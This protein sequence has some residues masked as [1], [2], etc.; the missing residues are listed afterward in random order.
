MTYMMSPVT[1][2]QMSQLLNTHQCEN[3]S[4]VY[5]KAGIRHEHQH[6]V[7]DSYNCLVY[8]LNK[9]FASLPEFLPTD[10]IFFHRPSN[11]VPFQV[12]PDG[13]NWQAELE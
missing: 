12:L 6:T 7:C 13:A 1:P 3:L 5:A 8:Q 10:R 2:E 9:G 11:T 4:C